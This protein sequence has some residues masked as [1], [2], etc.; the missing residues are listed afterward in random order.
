MPTLDESE[1]AAQRDFKEKGRSTAANDF[2]LDF[3]VWQGAGVYACFFYAV[4]TTTVL[5]AGHGSSD[6]CPMIF[7]ESF[8][9]IVIFQSSNVSMC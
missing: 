1:E 4:M 2:F 5:S 7:P 6:I 3:L 8:I 9:V